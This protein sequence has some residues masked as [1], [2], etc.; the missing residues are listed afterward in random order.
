M[1][2]HLKIAAALASLALTGCA[3][4]YANVNKADYDDCDY[5]A[6]VATPGSSSVLADAMRITDLRDMCLRNKGY[7]QSN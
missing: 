1:N 7:R 3:N 2:H 4:K 6:H 5:K